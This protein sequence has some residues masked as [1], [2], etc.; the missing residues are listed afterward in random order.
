MGSPRPISDALTPAMRR[1]L[2][3]RT[4]TPS[5]VRGLVSR[6][7][8]CPGSTTAR[9]AYTPLGRQVSA[10]LVDLWRMRAALAAVDRVLSLPHRQGLSGQVRDAREHALRALARTRPWADGS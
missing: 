4:A 9:L 8:A 7:L 5:T 3:G 2:C 6:R 1:A 10:M